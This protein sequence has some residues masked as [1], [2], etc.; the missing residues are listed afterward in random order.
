M[1]IAICIIVWIL[2]SIAEKSSE[3]IS[4]C[5]YQA[6]LRHQEDMEQRDRQWEELYEITTRNQ[7][8]NIQSSRKKTRTIVREAVDENG[9]MIR[10]T[11]T[12]EI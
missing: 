4:D 11:I 9:R 12:E 2:C 7:D 6:N 1:V 5:E 3:Q 8:T 10:E